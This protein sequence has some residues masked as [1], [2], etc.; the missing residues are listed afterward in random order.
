MSFLVKTLAAAL[1]SGGNAMATATNDG[2]M[3]QSLLME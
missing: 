3:L 2:Q 1:L